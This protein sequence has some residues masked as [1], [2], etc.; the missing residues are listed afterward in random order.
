MRAVSGNGICQ[1]A[2][3]M[4]CYEKNK[5]KRS[6]GNKNKSA[7]PSNAKN[8]NVCHHRLRDLEVTRDP[9][10]CAKAVRHTTVWEGRVSGCISCER[11]FL[12]VGGRG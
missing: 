3:C 2:V 11:E 6:R 4:E 5:P 12:K 7:C 10:W 8:E 9:W 1:Y